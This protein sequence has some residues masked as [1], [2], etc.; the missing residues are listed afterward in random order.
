MTNFN[1]PQFDYNAINLHVKMLFDLARG[2]PGKF[3]VLALTGDREDPPYEIAHFS[4]DG[5]D[6][7]IERMAAHL[8]FADFCPLV[9]DAGPKD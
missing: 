1:A 3:V 7:E 8:D 5:G 4:A 6:A 9:S 2:M